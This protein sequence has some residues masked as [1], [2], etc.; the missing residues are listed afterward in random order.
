MH[1]MLLSHDVP[2]KVYETNVMNTESLFIPA[3]DIMPIVKTNH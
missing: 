1:S 2:S 3:H